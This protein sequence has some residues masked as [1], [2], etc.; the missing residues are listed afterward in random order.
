MP[1]TFQIHYM[2]P[3]TVTVDLAN[4]TVTDVTVEDEAAEL[5]ANYAANP[6]ENVLRERAAEIAEEAT[7]PE[8]NIG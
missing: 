4:R 3:V 8:W 1:E 5:H 6:G 2:V 7:W